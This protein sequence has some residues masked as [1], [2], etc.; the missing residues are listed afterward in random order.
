MKRSK[1]DQKPEWRQLPAVED[2]VETGP[3]RFGDDW[4]GLFIRGDTCAYY[5]LHLEMLRKKMVEAKFPLNMLE[6]AA[7]NDLVEQM[8]AADEK[9]MKNP[10]GIK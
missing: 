1:N 10:T 8:E 2:R 6:W 9:N 4:T 7:F 3:I 5:R